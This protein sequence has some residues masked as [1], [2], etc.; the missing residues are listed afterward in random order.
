MLSLRELRPA[1][2]RA[3]RSLSNRPRRQQFYYVGA[4]DLT[5][6]LVASQ[7]PRRARRRLSHHRGDDHREHRDASL[8][9]EG[10]QSALEL[11][12][13][14]DHAGGLAALQRRPA[15]N[16]GPAERARTS[17]PPRPRSQRRWPFRT[18]AAISSSALPPRASTTG[19]RTA[20]PC[21][22]ADRANGERRWRARAA[23]PRRR[24]PSATATRA[25]RRERLPL[26]VTV[27]SDLPKSGA[28]SSAASA[29]CASLPADIWVTSLRTVSSSESSSRARPR[30]TGGPVHRSRGYHAFLDAAETELREGRPADVA[31]RRSRRRRTFERRTIGR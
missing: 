3:D 29:C 24:S 5:A 1:T 26:Q 8:R 18:L 21:G 6:Y 2:K 27:G 30:R 12:A 20:I 14:P 13:L 4:N 9:H 10:R 11:G 7:G 16:C 28:T 23:A 25:E 22:S 19:S 15:P 31:V 17:S